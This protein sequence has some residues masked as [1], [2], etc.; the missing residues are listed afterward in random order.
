MNPNQV[1]N[2]LRRIATAIE[3]SKRPNP[4]LVVQDIQLLVNKI[5]A[6]EGSILRDLEPAILELEKKMDDPER[7]KFFEG[8]VQ[9][10]ASPLISTANYIKEIVKQGK[11]VD[12]KNMLKEWDKAVDAIGYHKS[13][14]EIRSEKD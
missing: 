12:P 4:Q 1:T 14:E 5:A 2:T 7:G 9:N 3:K 13:T 11:A 6:G 10:L 8:V